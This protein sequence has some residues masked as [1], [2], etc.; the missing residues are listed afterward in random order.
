MPSTRGTGRSDP[1]P[2][3]SDPYLLSKAYTEPT[4]CPS[5]GLVFHKKRWLRDEHILSEVSDVAQKHKCPACRKIDDHYVMGQ[6]IVSGNFFLTVKDEMVN[7]IHNQEKKESFRNPLA[8]IMSLKFEQNNLVVET[9][10]D[11]L[12]VMIGKAIQ[13]SYNGELNI[14]FS[15]NK[16]ARVDWSRNLEPSKVKRNK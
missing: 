4:V 13:R 3:L 6:V 1:K 5:C 2:K 12:A 11:N 16:I 8:R 15:N 7:L 10:T 14:N 9:T